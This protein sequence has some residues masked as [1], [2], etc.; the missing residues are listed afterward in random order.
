MSPAPPI[1]FDLTKN[2]SSTAARHRQLTVDWLITAGDDAFF[3]AARR[4]R[5]GVSS[6]PYMCRARLAR[7]VG[8]LTL[9]YILRPF[10]RDRIL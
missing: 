2:P 5:L 10:H 6:A 3:A 9:A 4:Y 1:R 7:S 8:A